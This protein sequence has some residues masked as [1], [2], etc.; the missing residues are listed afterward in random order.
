MP[1]TASLQVKKPGQIDDSSQNDNSGQHG[2]R[3]GL[4]IENPQAVVA[5][6]SISQWTDDWWRWGLQAPNNP[7]LN[8]LLDTNGHAAQFNN[9]GK[10]FFI[11][12]TFPGGEVTRSLHVPADK[13]VLFP[14][15]NAFDTEGPGIE[16]LA[17]FKGSFADEAK[18]VTDLTRNSIYDAF[19]K[20]TRVGD[21]KPLVDLHFPATSKFS[22]NSEIFALGS[23]KPGSLLESLF[24]PALPLDPSVANLP[25][26]RSTG[27]W[28]MID[29]LRPGDYK[30]DFGGHG[31]EV[32]DPTVAG[33]TAGTLFAEGWGS[34]VHDTLHVG[35]HS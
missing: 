13:P 7:A 17:N 18:L 9:N 19:V 26:T 11:A 32:K 35:G 2:G 16:S 24:G 6:K 14:M 29:D 15:I 31:H 28:L 34:V 5:G 20:I 1:S 22:E 27:D 33:P 10:V 8:P 30:L 12:G 3:D 23:P 25:F 4:E 21:S